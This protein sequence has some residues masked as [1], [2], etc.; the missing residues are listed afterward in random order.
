MA[1]AEPSFRSTGTQRQESLRTAEG[2][3]DDEGRRAADG[4]R[5]Q[6]RHLS[7]R[8]RGQ[9][10]AHGRRHA[11]AV[12]GDVDARATDAPIDK[13]VLQLFRRRL[14]PLQW[15]PV[16]GARSYVV[17]VEDPDAKPVTPFVHW[18][19][20]NI[21]AGVTSLGEGLQKQPRLTSPDGVLQGRNS[22]ESVGWFGPRPPIGDPPHHYHV[23]VLALDTMLDVLPGVDRDTVLAAANGHIIVKGRIVGIY[24]QNERPLK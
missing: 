11:S 1:L 20:W 19:A 5:C 16:P 21:P 6:R 4:R 14:T 18:V 3:G 9:R 15:S 2:S 17:F 12:A 7:N 10:P 24:Q 22:R 8:L 13:K 23:E